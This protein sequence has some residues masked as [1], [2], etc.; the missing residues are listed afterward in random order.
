MSLSLM[1]FRKIV[2]WNAEQKS[3]YK[4]VDVCPTT[5]LDWTPSSNIRRG[6]RTWQPP[7][8]LMVG[9]AWWTVW[10]SLRLWTQLSTTSIQTNHFSILSQ[11]QSDFWSLIFVDVDILISDV[12]VLPAAQTPSTNPVTVWQPSQTK[13]ARSSSKLDK[14]KIFRFKLYFKKFCSIYNFFFVEL[15]WERPLLIACVLQW[16][17][18]CPV[19]PGHYLHC[20]G[21]CG[22]IWRPGWSLHRPQS[23]EYCWV[24]LLLQPQVGSA[25]LQGEEAGHL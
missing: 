3:C 15:E 12:S 9:S 6:L 13:Q 8:H 10:T 17:E 18:H 23:A 11:E 14:I 7:V 2:S 21:S 25:A 19:Q 16:Q 4:S 24:H 22:C 1:I 5:I 20:G